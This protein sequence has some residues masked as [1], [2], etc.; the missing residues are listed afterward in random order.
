MV[1]LL[2][3]PQIFTEARRR[4]GRLSSFLSQTCDCLE[5]K[6]NIWKSDI[7]RAIYGV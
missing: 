3:Q 1:S 2:Y 5:L 6:Y 4:R 7:Q